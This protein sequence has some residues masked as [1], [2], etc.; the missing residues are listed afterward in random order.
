MTGRRRYRVEETTRDWVPEKSIPA[1]L[2]L[3]KFV[4]SKTGSFNKACVYC[5]L[6]AISVQKIID[7]RHRMTA[8]VAKRIADG[9]KRIKAESTCLSHP[10]QNNP[11]S[12]EKK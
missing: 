11:A 7:G 3:L 8:L 4:E 9:Y 12:C 5:N 6:E 1:F 10:P 2:T